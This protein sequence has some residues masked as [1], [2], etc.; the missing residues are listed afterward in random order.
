MIMVDAD[1][2]YRQ[3]DYVRADII[4]KFMSRLGLEKTIFE[5]S[6]PKTSEWSITQYGP[7]VSSSIILFFLFYL[8][9]RSTILFLICQ[10]KSFRGSF[11]SPGSGMSSRL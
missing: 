4:A 3:A 2:I 6:N 8:Q 5:A 11:S 7:R 9:Y 10:G 1:D